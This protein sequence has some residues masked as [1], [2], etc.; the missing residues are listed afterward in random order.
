MEEPKSQL[1]SS[2]DH[3]AFTKY[4]KSYERHAGYCRRVRQYARMNRAFLLSAGWLDWAFEEAGRPFIYD[5]RLP[6]WTEEQLFALQS[7]YE[8]KQQRSK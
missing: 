8:K 3:K 1:L 6:V 5:S 4:R 2:E 7:E